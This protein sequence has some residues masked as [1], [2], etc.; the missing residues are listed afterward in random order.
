MLYRNLRVPIILNDILIKLRVPIIRWAYFLQAHVPPTSTSQTTTETK[1]WHCPDG[2]TG[3]PTQKKNHQ[4]ARLFP[5]IFINGLNVHLA[6][7]L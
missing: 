3:G 5:L 1:Q 2:P 4:T 6:M 7:G